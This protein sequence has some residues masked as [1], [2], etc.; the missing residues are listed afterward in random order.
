MKQRKQSK[1]FSTVLTECLKKKN[2]IGFVNTHKKPE[3]GHVILT[4]P[5]KSTAILNI[6]N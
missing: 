3:R 4:L 1:F 2:V 5:K 6:T